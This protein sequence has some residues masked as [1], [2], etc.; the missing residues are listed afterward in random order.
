MREWLV[1]RS[2]VSALDRV[3]WLAT[4]LFMFGL[5]VVVLPRL[6]T[7]PRLMDGWPGHLIFGALMV[8]AVV[9]LFGHAVLARAALFAPD[10]AWRLGIGEIHAARRT[11]FRLWRNRYGP[12]SVRKFELEEVADEGIVEGYKIV[13]GLKDGSWLRSDLIK[14]REAADELRVAMTTLMAPR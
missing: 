11:P 7:A 10:T 8:F 9:V 13:V 4:S 14:S 2:R 6:V 5:A 1:F 12:G 3:I